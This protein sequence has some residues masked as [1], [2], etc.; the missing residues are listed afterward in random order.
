MA[1]TPFTVPRPRSW[2]VD[3]YF[4]AHRAKLLDVAAFLDRVD[5]AP[6][7]DG[8]A[9]RN[10]DPRLVSLRAAIALLVDG[11]G[12]RARRILELFSDPS[13][14]PI[15]RAPGKGAIGVWPDYDPDA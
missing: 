14:D 2:V 4:M 15:D 1:E 8:A 10:D 3:T 9:V 5:R 6:P 11:E 12:D 7:D 13:T